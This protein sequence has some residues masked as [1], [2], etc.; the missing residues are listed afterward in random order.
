VSKGIF[1]LSLCRIR[2]IRGCSDGYGNYSHDNQGIVQV[3]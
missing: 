2:E 1:D 3:I